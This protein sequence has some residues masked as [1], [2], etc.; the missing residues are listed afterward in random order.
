MRLELHR[1][2]DGYAARGLRVLAIATR[3]LDGAQ[4]VPVDR[5]EIE[6]GLTLLGLVAMVDPPRAGVADAVADAHR[7]GIRIHVITGDYGLTAAEIAR[8]VGIGHAGR[9][10]IPG[11]ELD[12]LSDTQLGAVLAGNDEIVFARVS[13]EAK[14]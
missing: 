11:D 13:P 4:P 6:S 1:A 8:Q 7:A 5:H 3:T 14:L 2:L 12:R 10:V 9:R